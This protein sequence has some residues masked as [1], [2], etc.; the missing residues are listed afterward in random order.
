M[1]KISDPKDFKIQELEQ[2]IED[3]KHTHALEIRELEDNITDLKSSLKVK[4]RVQKVVHAEHT[5][6]YFPAAV[7]KVLAMIDPSKRFSEIYLKHLSF[8]N[9][10]IVGGIGVVINM[11]IL[12]TTAEFVPLWLADILAILVAWS[13]NWCFSVGPL[14]YLF[15]LSPRRRRVKKT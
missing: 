5:L 2:V 15:G 11:Y 9:Y 13:S 6:D 8:I 7:L 3:I 1:T 14:G 4:M 10:A 12:L